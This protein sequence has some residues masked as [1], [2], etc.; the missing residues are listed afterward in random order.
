M[1]RSPNANLQ[2]DGRFPV[3]RRSDRNKLFLFPAD[4]PAPTLDE[5]SIFSQ[6]QT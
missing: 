1:G 2:V 6:H 5:R 3:R 4:Q